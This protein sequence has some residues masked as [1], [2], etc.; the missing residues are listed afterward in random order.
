MMEEKKVEND[1]KKFDDKCGKVSCIYRDF[2]AELFQAEKS[3]RLRA[4]LSVSTPP[5]DRLI[6]HL[7]RTNG[8]ILRP[9]DS[10]FIEYLAKTD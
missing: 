2:D 4:G 8:G 5:N 1:E 6:E 9:P 7:E 10:R 3:N